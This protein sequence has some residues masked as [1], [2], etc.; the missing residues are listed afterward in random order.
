MPPPTIPGPTTNY[1][2][3]PLLNEINGANISMLRR[4]SMPVTRDE[5]RGSSSGGLQ[6]NLSMA[7]DTK[8]QSAMRG[9]VEDNLSDSD[10]DNSFLSR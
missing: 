9:P 6:D 3:F 7:L 2:L 5:K 8:F 1:P 10:D 4:S